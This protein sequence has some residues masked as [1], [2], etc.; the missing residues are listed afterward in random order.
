MWAIEKPSVQAAMSDVETFRKLGII[1]DKDSQALEHLVEQYDQQDGV[2]SEVQN[3]T[4]SSKGRDA[5]LEHYTDTEK[6]KELNYIRQELNEGVYKCPYCSIGQPETLDHYMPKSKYKSLALCRLNLIPMCWGCN[7]QKGHTHPFTEYIHPY[8]LKIPIGMVFLQADIQI[9]NK[10]L[11]VCFVIDETALNDKNIAKQLKTHWANMN[12]D[13]RLS[14]S[15][16]NF[17]HSEVLSESDEEDTIADEIDK[18]KCHIEK[19]YGLNNWRSAL[20]R[21]LSNEM[22]GLNRNSVME[23][24]VHMKRINR[25]IKI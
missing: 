22:K 8:Y 7:R 12:M 9:D 16:I 5:L 14:K 23:A 24:L 6:G 1:D 15:V 4:V 11:V 21:A 18:L 10:T 25:N 20:M 2:V 3:N 17:L 13:E 19:G